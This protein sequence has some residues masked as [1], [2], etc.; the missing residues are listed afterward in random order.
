MR[1]IHLAAITTLSF[2]ALGA[3]GG[4]ETPPPQPPTAASAPAPEP[5]PVASAT[6]PAPAPAPKPSQADLIQQTMKAFGDGMAAGD[7]AKVAALFTT[8]GV[9]T[10]YGPGGE[11][12]GRDAIQQMGQ[13]WIA[14]SK[15]IKMV[16][17]RVFLKGNVAINEMVCSG[18]MTG[19]FMGIK[20]SN[21]P[22][23]FVD[24][25]VM[26]FNDDGLIQSIHDYFD[27]PGFMAQ[28][29]GKKDAPPAPALPTGA[30]EVHVAK[31]TPDE[32]KAADF[33]KSFNDAFNKDAKT[34]NGLIAKDGDV[35]FYFLGGKNMKGK[36]LEAMNST[37]S[38]A[39]P[40]GQWTVGNVWGIDGYVIAER[41]MTG[42]WKGKLGPM[43]P[44]GKQ[45]TLHLLEILQPST[46]G[47]LQHG[48]AYGNV[49]E[50]A[51]PPPPKAAPA[52]KTA[53]A[54]APAAA[55]APAAAPKK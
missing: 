46:D 31:G 13:S 37:P 41:S 33:A 42:P 23:G 2:V 7:T 36:E 9:W 24:T 10:A 49:A 47:K 15:D 29:T 44:S 8:D 38:K 21:K 39:F 17:K 27:G 1:S 25:V 35:T 48:W 11:T 54:P 18:T 19:D 45:V 51:P 5:A 34:I 6:A 28:I 50:V 16:P 22:F 55:A 26:T 4:A 40:G 14:M 52:A 12:K 43:A 3:C 53:A 32:D 20:A 30:P